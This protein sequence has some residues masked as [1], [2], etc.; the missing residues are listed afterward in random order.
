M[1]RYIFSIHFTFLNSKGSGLVALS[2]I[3]PVEYR[4]HVQMIN[5]RIMRS[6]SSPR[7]TIRRQFIVGGEKNESAISH[8]GAHQTR[9]YWLLNQ[10]VRVHYIR[11]KDIPVL[12]QRLFKDLWDFF[13]KHPLSLIS[14]HDQPLNHKA[15]FIAMG[16]PNS[17]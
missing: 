14:N 1:I 11:S 10:R 13:E 12:M 3:P 15:Q 2:V 8:E 17:R 9:V 5:T 6:L 16:P 4:N 7:F